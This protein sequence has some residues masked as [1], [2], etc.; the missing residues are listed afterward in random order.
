MRS[1]YAWTSWRHVRRFAS[2]AACTAAIVVSMTSN[3]ALTLELCARTAPGS[4]STAAD[5][6]SIRRR[7]AAGVLVTGNL[8]ATPQSALSRLRRQL[9]GLR[10]GAVLDQVPPVAVQVLEDRHGPVRRDAGRPDE[11]HAGGRHAVVV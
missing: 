11:P 5:A 2:M 10:P 1:R 6:K 4:T 9:R 7:C 3:G 8:V